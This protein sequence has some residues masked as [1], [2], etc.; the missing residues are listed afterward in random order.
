MLNKIAYVSSIMTNAS[1]EKKL[2]TLL[3]MSKILNLQ[4]ED[5]NWIEGFLSFAKKKHP[6]PTEI[7]ANKMFEKKFNKFWKE[8]ESSDYRLP[9]GSLISSFIKVSRSGCLQFHQFQSALIQADTGESFAEF[10][11]LIRSTLSNAST[12]PLLDDQTGMLVSFDIKMGSLSIPQS[13]STRSKQVGL[14]SKIFERLPQFELASIEEILDIRKDLEMYLARFRSAMIKYSDSITSAQ[15]DSDFSYEAEQVFLR[16]VVPILNDIEEQV[17]SNKYLTMLT[18]RY[19]E[20]PSYFT[21]P[22]LSVALTHLSNL[23]DILSAVFGI[24]P[25]AANVLDVFN[26][27]RQKG[28]DI[29]K[30]QLFFYYAANKKFE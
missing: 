28:R 18:N 9:G 29:S 26:E 22:A 16:D 11:R 17:R 21:V 8:Y 1:C 24:A 27:W 15:W 3:D 12:Y 10:T 14:V 25:I 30:N 5:I 20:K 4:T 23:P 6:T 19:A 2:R 13:T 7:I